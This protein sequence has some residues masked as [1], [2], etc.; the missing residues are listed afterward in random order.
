[1]ALEPET[2][3]LEEH[4]DPE[5]K[6]MTRRFWVAVAFSVPLLI[7]VMGPHIPGLGLERLASSAYANWVQ[8]LLASPVVLWCGW[9]FFE[10]FWLSIKHRSLNMFTLIGLGVGISYLY[11]AFV[12]AAPG[13]LQGLTDGAV[14]VY[15]EPAAVIVTLVLL[16]QVLELKARAKTAGAIRAL[17]K[18]TPET[19]RKVNSDGSEADIPLNHVHKGDRLRVRPGENI[20]VDGVVL[21]GTSYVDQSMLT[22]EPVPVE[23]SAGDSVTGGTMNATGSFIM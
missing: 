18:L 23:K 20:P 13:L 19:A 6:D 21:E 10:R 2:V 16:G 9:P 1:M 7:F 17:L 22:G 8:L 5:L 4:E 12:V 14:P 11:S 15:F 3:S